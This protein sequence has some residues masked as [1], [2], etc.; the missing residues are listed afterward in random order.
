MVMP[1]KDIIRKGIGKKYSLFL[2]FVNK[3]DVEIL[4]LDWNYTNNTK[5]LNCNIVNY[6]NLFVCKINVSKNEFEILFNCDEKTVK[7]INKMDIDDEIKKIAN[8]SI[9]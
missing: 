7:E 1:E 6:M 8:E 2:E 9:P 4:T 5:K 3:I